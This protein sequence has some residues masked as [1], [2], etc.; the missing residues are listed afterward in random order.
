MSCYDRRMK[1]SKVAIIKTSPAT[2]LADYHRL[3]NLVDYQEYLPKDKET[4][5]QQLDFVVSS[6]N[7]KHLRS[8]DSRAL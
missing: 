2:V 1:K 7:D 3:M 6:R 5:V 4:V 8:E